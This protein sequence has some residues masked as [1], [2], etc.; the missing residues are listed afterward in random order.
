MCGSEQVGEHKDISINH[1]ITV[2]H[3]SLETTNYSS[4]TVPC[5][6]YCPSKNVHHRYT[7]L[8]I[9]SIVICCPSQYL[10]VT[11]WRNTKTNGS[12]TEGT[13]GTAEALA[14]APR[15]KHVN[16]RFNWNVR[17]YLV[18][19]TLLS[20]FMQRRILWQ[21]YLMSNNNKITLEFSKL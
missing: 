7:S 3:S 12:T 10:F 18:L 15:I 5:W 8:S 9:I 1:V 13:A 11:I 19:A 4:V 14:V 6:Y 17:R 16:S 21:L 20:M 2:N